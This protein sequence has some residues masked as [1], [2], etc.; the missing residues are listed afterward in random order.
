[1]MILT[2]QNANIFQGEMLPFLE[3]LLG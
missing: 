1:M 2:V 3:L